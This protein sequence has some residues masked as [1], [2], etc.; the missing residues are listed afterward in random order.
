MTVGMMVKS[1]E[2][3]FI[4]VCFVNHSTSS[5]AHNNL[6]SSFKM[7]EVG[8]DCVLSQPAAGLSP[9]PDWLSRHRVMIAMS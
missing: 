7:S 6:K 3:F 9:T 1:N 4:K 5:F 8:T 2:A